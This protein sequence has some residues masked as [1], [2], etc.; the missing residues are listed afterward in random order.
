MKEF[1]GSRNEETFER[2]KRSLTSVYKIALSAFLVS[3]A[4]FLGAFVG[5]ALLFPHALYSAFW[6]PNAIMLAVFLMT[7]ARRWWVYLLAIIPVHLVAVG[8]IGTPYWRMFWQIGINTIM[9]GLT[10]V[11]LQRFN[12]DNMRF[13]RR[14]PV[15]VYLATITASLSISVLFAPAVVLALLEG[16]DFGTVWLAGFFSN[17]IGF[18]SLTPIILLCFAG[19]ISWVRGISLKNWLEKII[20]TVGLI[21]ICIYVYEVGSRVSGNS[22]TLLYLPLPILLWS[23]VRFGSRGTY[24]AIM[25]LSLITSWSGV[26]GYGPFVVQSAL[27]GVIILQLFLVSVSIPLM[28]L[29][30][31]IQEQEWDR[32]ELKLS[33]EEIRRQFAQLSTIYRTTPIGLAFLDTDLRFVRINDHLAEIHGLPAM[34]H[35]NRTFREMLPEVADVAEPVYRKVIETGEPVV[36]IVGH[37]TTRSQPGVIRDWLIDKYPVKDEHGAVIGVHRILMDIY[38]RKRAERAL[39]ESEAKFRGVFE[40]DIVPFI[41]W[42]ADG[43]IVD[44]NDAF[45][46]LTG[47]TRGEMEEGLLRWWEMAPPKNTEPHDQA[48]DENRS[49]GFRTVIEQEYEL[50]DGRRVPVLVGS[51]YLEGFTDRG[52]GFALDLT[53]RKSAEEALRDS[54]ERL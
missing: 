22:G 48:T 45:L 39:R 11:C 26:N 3:I 19:G 43:R 30:A 18:I 33:S 42:Q 21:A 34:D 37:G 9:T 44:A 31:V 49:G 27:G 23:S 25:I 35:I 40:S 54:E 7:P 28:L 14:R 46:K 50:R 20:A 32:K 4:Y 2:T 10:A 8:S 52:V 16:H 6:P 53:E 15:L 1:A 47:F 12:K 24:A 38:E 29:A 5:L 13:D 41:F 51:A 17:F 36:G